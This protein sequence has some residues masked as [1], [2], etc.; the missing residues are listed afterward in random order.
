LKLPYVVVLAMLSGV[1]F[2]QSQGQTQ[3]KP[4]HV[5]TRPTATVTSH[6]SLPIATSGAERIVIQYVNPLHYQYYLQVTSTNISA[7]TPPSSIAPSASI[8]GTLPPPQPSPATVAPST[9]PAPTAEQPTKLDDQWQNILTNLKDARDRAFYWKQQTDTL[10][11]TASME[12]QCYK[13][14]LS[15]YSSFLLDENTANSLK[16]F[17]RKN[18]DETTSGA[19]SNSASDSCRR[20]DDNWPF[21]ALQ[22]TEKQI[23][24]LQS[25]LFDF[26]SA[27]GF[28]KWK[29][30]APNGDNYTAVTALVASLLTQ[31]QSLEATSDVAKNFQAAQVYNHFW[32]VKIQDIARSEY[33][34]ARAAEALDRDRAAYQNDQK[35]ASLRA[36]Y[37][38]SKNAYIAAR[39]RSPLL[40][41]V[42]V[43][44]STNWYGRG[45]T[46]TITLHY[47]DITATP[48]TDQNTQIAVSS[49]L[50][51]GT[52]STGIGMSFLR[53]RQFAFVSGRDPNNSANTISVIGTTTDQ[54][55]TPLYA[56]QYNIALKD[57][58]KG[59]GLHAAVGAALGSSSGTANIELL[60]GPSI[61]I[62]RRA[63][64]ITP[65]FQLGRRD[66]LLPGFA[67]GNA[68]GNG[69]TAIPVHT[70]W[71]PGFALTFSFSVAQ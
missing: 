47:T 13:D 49:C 59:L 68:Q 66:E 48:A 70:S 37:D 14:R 58:S 5:D 35:N 44:C 15:F 11:F 26:A 7:P 20:P 71:K 4:N 45:R 1:P 43:D 30:T 51:P 38:D 6:T 55:V 21:D 57:S 34:I 67:I 10:L 2:A 42:Y 17:V 53:N 46:D 9:T 62:R 19:G 29:D 61:S 50:T 12:E 41:T 60:A 40:L 39:Q 63:F 52:V 69:L 24:Q 64:F 22:T 16:Q 56:V 23:Y 54:Q 36:A 65:A 8:S 31:V 28:A 32:R 3:S 18:T 25:S 33:E 27:D